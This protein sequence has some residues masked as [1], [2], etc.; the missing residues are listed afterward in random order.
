M[1]FS[2]NKCDFITKS[3]VLIELK[4]S[5]SINFESEIFNSIEITDLNL[6]FFELIDD[7][8]TKELS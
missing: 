2:S 5:D 3:V 8:W 7:Y 1:K 6:E 4:I